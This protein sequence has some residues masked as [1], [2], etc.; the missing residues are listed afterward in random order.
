MILI[1]FHQTVIATIASMSKKD[2]LGMD[3]KLIRHTVLNTMRSYIKKFKL[4]YGPEIVLCFDSKHSWRKDIFPY[5]KIT[6][7]LHRENSDLN[8]KL[9]FETIDKIHDELKN[10]FPYKVIGVENAEADDII[11]TLVKHKPES[12]KVVI[13]SSDKDFKQLQKFPNVSQYSPLLKEFLREPNHELFLR[14]HIITGD[15]GD[16]VPN[17]LSP[18]D[19]FAM[20]A[21]QRTISKRKLENWLN[22][23][24]MP[25]DETE[26]RGYDR[27]RTLIDLDCIP[28]EVDSS[29]MEEYNKPV[30]KVSKTEML[31]YFMSQ[32]LGNLISSLED[33]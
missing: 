9:I 23:K 15:R 16:G 26:K 2:K 11:A 33:F 4:E 27:N 28:S 12:E 7:K 22:S 3:A 5:Y 21:R 17:I 19:T 1:D 6:R 13:V 29:I 32:K 25:F 8:W 20:N 18:D 31:N 14:E 30:K 10:Y 24:I